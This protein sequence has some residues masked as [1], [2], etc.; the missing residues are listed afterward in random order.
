MAEHAAYLRFLQILHGLQLNY[1]AAAAAAAAL[2]A[3]K[4]AGQADL[5]RTLEKLLQDYQAAKSTLYVQQ[6]QHFVVNQT[7]L[8]APETQV[9]YQ[10]TVEPFKYAPAAAD[11]VA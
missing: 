5:D 11:Q 4:V 3:V 1:G 8:D 6:D 9:L 7:E 10:S 2:V